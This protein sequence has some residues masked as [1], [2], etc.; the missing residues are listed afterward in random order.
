MTSHQ[1]ALSENNL[2][3]LVYQSSRKQGLIHVGR[4]VLWLP[5][6]RP[7]KVNFIHKHRGGKKEKCDARRVRVANHV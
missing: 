2:K 7:T 3:E 4:K 6:I 1:I 5:I